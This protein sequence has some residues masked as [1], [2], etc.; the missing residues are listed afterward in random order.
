M[1]AQLSISFNDPGGAESRYYA[2]VRTVLNQ[3]FAAWMSHFDDSRGTVTLN[4]GFK[5]SHGAEAA[6][7]GPDLVYRVG[8]TAGVPVYVS[9]FALAAVG[10]ASGIQASATLTLDTTFL[11]QS[12]PNGVPAGTFGLTVMEHELGHAL[13]FNTFLSGAPFGAPDPRLRTAFDQSLRFAPG[14]E[15]FNGA[16]AQASYGGPVP[17]EPASVAHTYAPGGASVMSYLQAAATIQPLDVAILRDAGLPALSDRELQEHEVIRLYAAAFGRAADDAGVVTWTRALASGLSLSAVAGQFAGSAEFA[18]RYGANAGDKAFV[19][20]LYGN[21]LGRAADA[22]GERAWTS[23]LAGG[24]SRGDVLLGFSDSDEERARLAHAPN[25]SY[26]ATVEAQAQ[27]LYDTAFGRDADPAGF[28]AY[29]AAL[30]G[31]ASLQQAALSFLASPEFANRYGAQPTNQAL[32]DAFYQNT[33]HRAPDA[34]GKKGW[35]D[36]LDAGRITRADLLAGFSEAPEHVA[37]VVLR[38]QAQA[39]GGYVADTTVHLGEIPVF[40]Q[41][42]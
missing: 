15:T 6:D 19:D 12:F 29:T 24:R 42:G 17:M 23:A 7:C 34:A 35:V 11:S 1:T 16:Y 25:A 22:G 9:G 5:D 14:A 37:A 3:A 28:D 21:V 13:G 20:A 39:A 38:E 18:N 41:R 10:G 36:A 32:V 33:L 31:G 2:G 40:W 27:R 8:Y 26:A 30:M 4:V